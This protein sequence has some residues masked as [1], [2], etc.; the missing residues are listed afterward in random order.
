MLG[1]IDRTFGWLLIL[2][3]CAHAM[4]TILGYP[5]MS[6]IFLWSLGSSLAGLLLG[7]LNII[8]AGRPSDKTLA[9]ITFAGTFCW[10]VLALALGKSI[11]NIFDPRPFLTA[12]FSAVLVVFSARTLRADAPIGL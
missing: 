8:R 5:L 12:I 2:G 3:A 11:G 9:A 10:L 4:G 7:A 6:A 1:N